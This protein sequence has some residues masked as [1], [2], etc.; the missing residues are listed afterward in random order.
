M[1]TNAVRLQYAQVE[2]LN[3]CGT[4]TKPINEVLKIIDSLSS[5]NLS[6]NVKTDLPKGETGIMTQKIYVLT[7]VKKEFSKKL[8]HK[9]IFIF[10]AKRK[11]SE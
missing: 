6:I 5:G 8:K 9:S 4:I 3:P 7:G 10:T 1:A 11:V 2:R